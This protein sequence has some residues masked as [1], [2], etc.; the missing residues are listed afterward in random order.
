ML[1]WLLKYHYSVVTSVRAFQSSRACTYYYIVINFNDFVVLP[2]VHR[3][4]YLVLATNANLQRRI[5][6]SWRYAWSQTITIRFVP[7]VAPFSSIVQRKNAACSIKFVFPSIISCGLIPTCMIHARWENGCGG[8]G[9][10]RVYLTIHLT[11]LWAYVIL[12]RTFVVQGPSRLPA[13][14]SI[15]MA[16]T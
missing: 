7:R 16:C 2:H 3:K 9:L 4:S 5:V 8:K 14:I 6:T 15:D 12:L 10:E 13:A 1:L 11:C